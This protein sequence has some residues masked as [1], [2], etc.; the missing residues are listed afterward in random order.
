MDAVD[1]FA[2]NDDATAHAGTQGGE[3][4]VLAA[5]AAALPGFAQRGHVGVVAGGDCQ[6]GEA[7]QDLGNV[8]D[9]PA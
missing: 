9:T 3:D 6:A 4:H 8:D 7:A 1:H 2:I 5:L